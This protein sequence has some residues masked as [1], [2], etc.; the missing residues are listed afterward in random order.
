VESRNRA[1][2]PDHLRERLD[3]FLVVLDIEPLTG[4]LGKA[5]VEMARQEE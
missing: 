5:G 4:N 3:I 2:G 1:I